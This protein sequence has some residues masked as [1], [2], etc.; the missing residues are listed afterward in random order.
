MQWEVPDISAPA[1]TVPRQFPLHPFTY[2]VSQKGLLHRAS[3]PA[4]SLFRAAIAV[5]SVA[6][7]VVFGFSDRLQ[8][9]VRFAALIQCGKHQ[10]GIH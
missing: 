3:R 5:S 8:L 6:A 1:I 10:I 9:L 7:G 2:T 4:G